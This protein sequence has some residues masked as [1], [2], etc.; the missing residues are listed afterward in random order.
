MGRFQRH[1]V[2][3][4]LG[5]ARRKRTAFLVLAGATAMVLAGY[6]WPR[7]EMDVVTAADPPTPASALQQPQGVG[8]AGRRIAD[9]EVSYSEPEPSVLTAFLDSPAPGG[10]EQV[11]VPAEVPTGSRLVVRP[12][13]S[14]DNGHAV[15][16]RG[17]AVVLSVQGGYLAFYDALDESLT[18]LPGSPCGMVGGRPAVARR[19]LGGESVLW[20][21]D[22]A[23]HGVFAWG[24]SRSVVV[25]VACSMRPVKAVDHAGQMAVGAA[26]LRRIGE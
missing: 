5:S 19:V 10:V 16:R 13:A 7:P 11:F 21:A 3:T 18:Q 22:G 15:A 26:G 9:E 8:L 2:R 25:R 12:R 1:E 4:L 24:L 17:P 6:A 23:L 14:G 20:E